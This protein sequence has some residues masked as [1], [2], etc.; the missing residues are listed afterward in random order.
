MEARPLVQRDVMSIP[1][2]GERLGM[3]PRSA[4]VAAQRGLFPV[5]TNGRR[6]MVSIRAFERWLADGGGSAPREEGD[7]HVTWT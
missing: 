4:Y 3:K 2:A 7:G 5:I 6:K 1:E